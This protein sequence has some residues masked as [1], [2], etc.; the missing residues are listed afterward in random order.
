[1]NL[2]T[3]LESQLATLAADGALTTLLGGAHIYMRD[4]VDVVEQVPGLYWWGPDEAPLEENTQRATVTWDIWARS[5]DQAH[6]IEDRV[7]ELLHFDLPQ[8]FGTAIAWSQYR[9]SL[10]LP[11]AKGQSR[12]V[13]EIELLPVRDRT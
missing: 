8:T 11:A 4:S 6:D 13:M 10:V 7:R 2:R 1:V 9:G 12:R 3:V 5:S